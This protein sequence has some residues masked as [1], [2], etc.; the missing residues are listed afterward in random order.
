MRKLNIS[1]L[2]ME[3]CS[4]CSGTSPFLISPDTEDTALAM[5]QLAVALEN[6]S[7]GLNLNGSLE[8]AM[9]SFYT[10]SGISTEDHGDAAKYGVIAAIVA[11]IVAAISWCLSKM[12]GG[13]SSIS[14]G[15]SDIRSNAATIAESKTPPPSPEFTAFKKELWNDHVKGCFG[16]KI[17]DH[18]TWFEFNKHFDEFIV[19]V[20]Q[21]MKSNIDQYVKVVDEARVAGTPMT[22][23]LVPYDVV[24][25]YYRYCQKL[26]EK[27]GG[28][29]HDVVGDR[30]KVEH[31][32]I[33]DAMS[34]MLS[35]CDEVNTMVHSYHP[36]EDL[37]K[38]DHLIHD[39]FISDEA[40]KKA[41]E[42]IKEGSAE[43]NDL[44]KLEK[45]FKDLLKRSKLRINGDQSV[46]TSLS[47]TL[48]YIKLVLA[49]FNHTLQD[50][51][52]TKAMQRKYIAF[53]DKSKATT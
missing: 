37:S 25:K 39:N 31:Y 30:S 6:I 26:N 9:A 12:M 40:I 46:R 49:N 23:H 35:L 52:Y 34:Q 41:E 16:L 18:D 3:A 36:P 44:G 27:L 48:R 1:A 24:D 33:I 4:G 50:V 21:S 15:I 17:V 2:A 38:L 47:V 29:P 45:K 20:M 51:E 22:M 43:I 42:A 19:S 14:S 13:K 5:E 32:R 53:V 7:E 11:A 28:K 10:A 8:S